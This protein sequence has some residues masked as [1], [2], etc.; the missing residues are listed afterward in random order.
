MKTLESK[1]SIKEIMY[2]KNRNVATWCSFYRA[3]PHRFCKDYLNIN[4]RLFQ[5]ILIYAMMVYD[6]F[7]F[8]ACRGLGKTWLT[9]L[10]CVLRCILYPGTKICV[11]SGT[12]IQGNEVLSKILDDFCVLHGYGSENL[13]REISYNCIN[14]SAGVIKFHNGSWIKVVT[15]RDTA[16]GN[17]A[18]I[19]ICDEFRM[20]KKETID[21]V[22]KRFLSD[23]REPPYLEKSE[24]KHLVENNKE[25]YMSSA[26][27]SSHWSY[28]KAKTYTK[29]MLNDKK[30]YFICALP[31][32]LAIKERLLQMSDI[33]DEMSEEDFDE[34]T[35]SMEMEAIWYGDMGGSFF[36]FDNIDEARKIKIPI[37][38]LNNNHLKTK[39]I[40]DLIPN[41]KR[42]LSVDVAL[43][44][45]RKKYKNDASS[46][47]INSAIP[48]NNDSY[49][50]NIVYLENHEG[51]NT[52]ELAFIVRK[53]YKVYKCTDIALDTNG[54][55]LGVYDELIKDMFDPETGEVYPA[56]SCCN[57][58]VMAERCKVNN[59]PQVIWSIKATEKFNNDACLL[60]RSGFQKKKINL[61]VSELD[62]EEILVNKIKGYKKLD[63][64]EQVLYKMPYIQ[65]TLLVHELVN[66]KYEATGNL[67]KVKEKSGARKDRYSSLAYN[68]WVMCQLE[69]KLLGNQSKGFSMRDYAKRLNKMNRKPTAY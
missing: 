3:N 46:I 11:C 35:F 36:S 1:K 69:R 4:L 19:L 10:Y 42:I 29:N 18:N 22:L 63:L 41:E 47:M 32:Q 68:Y 61:L 33:E 25:I 48:T 51:L 50:A 8:I 43:M 23:T 20:I 65:T 58:K 34:V 30:K 59:A 57:D 62:T 12:R 39:D 7:M 27:Y 64:T 5:K 67:V 14:S 28:K 66:L 17:R 15:P 56:L 6:H 37:Y 38:P 55:G 9:S 49:I 31:Y 53:L 21:T 44:V 2:E 24:Y 54:I 52:D 26:W 45:S 60:L 16:R 40:P 13:K